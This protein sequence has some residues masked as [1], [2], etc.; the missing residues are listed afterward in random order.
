VAHTGRHADG[1][2]PNNSWPAV[3]GSAGSRTRRRGPPRPRRYASWLRVGM[4]K[5]WSARKRAW[6]SRRAVWGRSERAAGRRLA[7]ERGAPCAHGAALHGAGRLQAGC[8]GSQSGGSACYS[9]FDASLRGR[10]SGRHAARPRTAACPALQA[11]S[12]GSVLA[13]GDQNVI[14]PEPL[15]A[16]AV[17]QRGDVPALERQQ[18]RPG[19]HGAVVDA[20]ALVCGAC[21]TQTSAGT[22]GRQPAL[23][24]AGTAVWGPGMRRQPCSR[25]SHAEART[26]CRSPPVAYR[27]PPRS[28]TMMPIMSCSRWLQPTPPTMSTS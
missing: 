26:A 7:R 23:R 5:V 24:P 4:N 28:S 6:R 3:A 18:P 2:H 11:G 17:L 14:R 15:R 27:R 20:V 25:V 13:P 8:P 10:C 1:R 16:G 19:D 12:L 9:R 22:P 21:R